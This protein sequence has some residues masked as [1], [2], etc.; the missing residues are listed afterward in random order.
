[1]TETHT[2]KSC[3]IFAAQTLS[4]EKSFDEPWSITE[5]TD[6]LSLTYN[7]TNTLSLSLS[8]SRSLFSQ[9]HRQIQAI[10]LSIPHFSASFSF[11][12]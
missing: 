2:N 11:P 6:I 8:L 10:P 1:M 7:I 5:H 12:P 3:L 9:T 4:K